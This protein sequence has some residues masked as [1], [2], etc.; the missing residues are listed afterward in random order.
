M[1]RVF[2]AIFLTVSLAGFANAQE[3]TGKVAEQVKSEILKLEQEKEKAMTST[4]SANN[5]AADWVERV[6]ADDIAF[7]N[8]YG[9]YTKAE[10]VAQFRAGKHK[11]YTVKAS[12][13]HVRVYGNGGDGTTAVITYINE[14]D[15]THTG[16]QRSPI[17]TR[18]TDV[19][20]KIDGKWRWVVHHHSFMESA[21]SK[22]GDK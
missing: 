19:F 4:T 2:S 16:Q 13:N 18:G 9:M 1:R 21:G 22:S 10:V 15:G 5:Y 17:K 14:S 7:T 11:T 8:P 12:D 3:A 6:D 20:V